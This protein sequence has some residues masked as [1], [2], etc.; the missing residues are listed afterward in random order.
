M[1]ESLSEKVELKGWCNDLIQARAQ[2]CWTIVGFGASD[3]MN[4]SVL[5]LYHNICQARVNA[6]GGWG[7]GPR[8]S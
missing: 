4:I 1:T 2:I 6:V 7:A 3:M 8:D 5:R